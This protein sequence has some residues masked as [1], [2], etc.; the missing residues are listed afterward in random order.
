MWH[1]VLY[2]GCLLYVPTL[3]G[4]DHP[5]HAKKIEQTTIQTNKSGSESNTSIFWMTACANYRN[6]TQAHKTKQKQNKTQQK[7][8]L[9]TNLAQAIIQ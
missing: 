9:E 7:N 6:K 2:G 3:Y 5:H 8:K 1:R 4:Y